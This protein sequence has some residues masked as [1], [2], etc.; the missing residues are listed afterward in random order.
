M[1]K[2]IG[3]VTRRDGYNRSAKVKMPSGRILARPLN[4]PFPVETSEN[5]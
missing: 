3:L 2:I 5:S 1:G 4:L